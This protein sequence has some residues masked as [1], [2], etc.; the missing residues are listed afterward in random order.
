MEALQRHHSL[1]HGPALSAC[2]FTRRW[3][4]LYS[5]RLC[6]DTDG[7][8]AA[9]FHAPCSHMIHTWFGLCLSSPESTVN[10]YL[11]NPAM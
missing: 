3:H 5:S 7:H 9:A 11:L 4:P 6:A 8:T 2:G 1:E 10:S